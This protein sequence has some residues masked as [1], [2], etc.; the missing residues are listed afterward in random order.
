MIVLSCI[1]LYI[2]QLIFFTMSGEENTHERILKYFDKLS[3]IIF[4]SIYGL[5]RDGWEN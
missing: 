2:F 3:C 5:E 4:I 1:D